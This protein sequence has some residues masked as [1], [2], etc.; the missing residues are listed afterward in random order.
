[1][2]EEK[3]LD[4]F[5]G[6]T[7]RW[8]VGSLEGWLTLLLCLIAIG[9]VLIFLK[10]LS[11][12]AT[13]FELT[14]QRLIIRKGI[15]NK[16]IDEIELYRVK[17]VTV[18]FSILGQMADIGDIK[19]ISS[20]ITSRSTV[21]TMRDVHRARGR[22]EQLRKLVEENRQRRRVREVDLDEVGGY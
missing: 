13:S 17:D 11:N 10:W 12:V 1:M 19:I 18:D 8:L 21:M 16:T 22:R 2:T 5:R 14:D 7:G 15:I 3:Q 4:R 9:F 20:D 6:H